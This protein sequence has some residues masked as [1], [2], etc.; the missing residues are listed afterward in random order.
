MNTNVAKHFAIP[1][2]NYSFL[3]I[4]DFL[5]D[6]KNEFLYSAPKQKETKV[7]EFGVVLKAFS[8]IKHSS[9]NSVFVITF[10]IALPASR[11]LR[12][13]EFYASL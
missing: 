5:R 3:N 4:L 10:P 6:D 1:R 7:I 2:S 12:L 11:L 8:S 13:R 9:G